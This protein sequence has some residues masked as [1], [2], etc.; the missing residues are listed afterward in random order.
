MPASSTQS[1]FWYES[2]DHNGVSPFIP[3][4]SSW[5]VFRNVVTDF[6]AVGDGVTDDWSAIQNAINSGNSFADRTSNSL[7]TTGQP[8]VVYI[9][10]GTYMLSQPLQLYVGTVV[11]GNPI[12]RPTLKVTSS[13]SGNTVIYGK[14]PNQGSTTNF[15]IGFK[16]IILDSTN[17]SPSTTITLMDWSVSQATQLTNVE[18]NMPNFSTGHTGIAM[19]EGGSGTIINDLTFNGGVVGIVSNIS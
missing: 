3:D 4:S 8:A 12:N 2:I 7:G 19:P 1:D 6:G 16:N 9:P 14:D 13:F 10:S 11:L 18:F 17:L 15:Y 5:S